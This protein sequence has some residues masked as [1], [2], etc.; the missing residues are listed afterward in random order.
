MAAAVVKTTVRDLASGDEKIFGPA[1]TH[2]ESSVFVGLCRCAGY[3]EGLLDT[4][5]DVVQLSRTQRQALCRETLEILRNEWDKH[6]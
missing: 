6:S 2:L 1:R 4:L 3:P 5:R